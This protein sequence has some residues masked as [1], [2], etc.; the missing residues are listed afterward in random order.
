MTNYICKTCGTQFAA[1]DGPPVV[2]PICAD[3]RQY[4]G[5]DGQQWTTL[6]EVREAHHNVIKTVEPNLT[7][8]GAHPDLAIAQRAL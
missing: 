8:I 1:T 5:P 2:C 4:I 3:E 7:G 6:D